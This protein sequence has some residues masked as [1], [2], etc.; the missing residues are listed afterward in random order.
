M[1]PE[2]PPQGCYQYGLE[3]EPRAYV[4][5]FHDLP[6][7]RPPSVDLLA[8]F[9]GTINLQVTACSLRHLPQ[10]VTLE[11]LELVHDWLAHHFYKPQI[12][13]GIGLGAHLLNVLPWHDGKA[14]IYID[15]PP[16]NVFA[17]ATAQD[18]FNSPHVAVDRGTI[19]CDPL[20]AQAII[21]N[22]PD[23]PS[24]EQLWMG[25]DT[26]LSQLVL[27]AASNHLHTAHSL[28]EAGG[29][30]HGRLI[31]AWIQT[32]FT[33]VDH[34][35]EVD[36]LPQGL[37]QVHAQM[38]DNEQIALRTGELSLAVS[39]QAEASVNLLLLAIGHASLL[40][41]QQTIRQMGWEMPQIHITMS[42]AEALA[43]NHNG[44]HAPEEG[45]V[46]HIR[47]IHILDR[48]D[49]VRK[50]LLHQYIPTRIAIG[51]VDIPLINRI[52]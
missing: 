44:Q 43:V 51:G 48:M 1:R 14:L 23:K 38:L 6:E 52:R 28:A 12:G 16:A 13:V 15:A 34:K 33:G 39:M 25:Q 9:L 22:P 45:A 46:R 8:Q 10:P 20:L 50:N 30:L 3:G 29:L 35:P 26:S 47:E 24:L 2:I 31:S 11:A 17:R 19:E 41:L 4:L 18:L 27:P 36:T 42:C 40:E 32:L 5:V 21:R 37:Y 49:E 7:L